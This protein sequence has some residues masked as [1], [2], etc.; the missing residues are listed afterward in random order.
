MPRNATVPIQTETEDLSLEGFYCYIERSFLPGEHLKFLILLPPAAKGPLAF[1]GLCLQ[2]SME[3]VRLTAASDRRYG[4][5]CRVVSYR[6]LS[7]CEFLTPEGITFILLENYHQEYRSA[8]A[9]L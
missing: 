3:V 9:I 8:G 6:V 7:N 2:G 5:G 4:L 1:R